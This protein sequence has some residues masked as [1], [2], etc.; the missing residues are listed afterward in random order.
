MGEGGEDEGNLTLKSPE[1]PG[2]AEQESGR[3]HAV[4]TRR[5]QG[6][7]VQWE[8]TRVWSQRDGISELIQGVLST[9]PSLETTASPPPLTTLIPGG[10]PW[11]WRGLL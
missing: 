4:A 5:S 11:D 9:E 8:R 3:G 6:Q 10:V 7:R 2:L 1:G